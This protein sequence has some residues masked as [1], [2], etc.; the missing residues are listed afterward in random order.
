M[1]TISDLRPGDVLFYRTTKDGYPN[2]GIGNLHPANFNDFHVLAAYAQ[3][4]PYSVVRGHYRPWY[5]VGLVA[6]AGQPPTTIQFDDGVSS[7]ESQDKL[8]RTG[9]TSDV[10]DPRLLTG[11]AQSTNL[12]GRG[13]DVLRPPSKG[14][15]VDR[16]LSEA[17]RLLDQ[18]Y[19]VA[20][21]LGYA[22]ATQAW[23]IPD[24][25]TDLVTGRI[26]RE[27][28]LDRARGADARARE[29]GGNT[30]SCVTSVARPLEVGLG[31]VT[32]TF[33]EPP[34]P[35][36][37]PLHG[38]HPMFEL[39]RNTINR[40]HRGS[41]GAQLQGTNAQRMISIGRSLAKE[42]PL[43]GD[44]ALVSEINRCLEDNDQ[45]QTIGPENILLHEHQQ[46]HIPDV[47]TTI[48]YI[49]GPS[50]GVG[51]YIDKLEQAIVLVSDGPSIDELEARGRELAGQPLTSTS[52]LVS[53][54]MLWES[55]LDC[56][57]SHINSP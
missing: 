15:D 27:S 18:P 49:I 38:G 19:A 26:L 10:Y 3:S 48:Q 7:G 25:P 23:M 31:N 34:P 6:E 9:L 45:W 51:E 29:H 5:H 47:I 20:G 13:I 2:S 11:T 12:S 57:F 4:Y 33:S 43:P 53:P 55:L 37:L 56:G 54:A 39:I 52:Y 44:P 41:L 21:L 17:E 46:E 28:L 50:V 1:V 40:L 22:L 14:F 42:Q 32:L 8:R 36:T 30:E 24:D 16:C 35:P